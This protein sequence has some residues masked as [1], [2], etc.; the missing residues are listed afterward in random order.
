MS[1]IDRVLSSL[2]LLAVLALVSGCGLQLATSSTTP[3]PDSVPAV[4]ATQA[5]I[6]T[7]PPASPPAATPQLKLA[8][9]ITESA[10]DTT[11]AVTWRVGPIEYTPPTAV[12][13]ACNLVDPVTLSELAYS[14]G[15][16]TI[17]YTQGSL[18][19]PVLIQ[20]TYLI[21][22]DNW[23]GVVAFD[24]GGQWQCQADYGPITLDVP[25][26]ST[27]TY[28]VWILSQVLSNAEPTVTPAE[29][30]SWQI[31]YLGIG[32]TGELYPNVTIT[33]P[34]AADCAGS[35][36]LMVYLQ[37]PA[38]IQDPNTGETDS[39]SPV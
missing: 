37:H 35:D 27:G 23:Q 33:G 6:A 3:A 14:P 13:N 5:T 25:P 30:D 19:E 34:N 7:S 29:A 21:S 1:C 24:I 4:S 12:L 31:S 15:E 26:H 38:T 22:G 32:M 20:T 18:V 36:V 11:I 8:G 28:P 9:T 2:T 10:N 17:A 16:V 39:C